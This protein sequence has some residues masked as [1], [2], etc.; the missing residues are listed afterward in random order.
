MLHSMGFAQRLLFRKAFQTFHKIFDRFFATIWVMTALTRALQ[1]PY[2]GWSDTSHFHEISTYIIAQMAPGTF[3][4]SLWKMPRPLWQAS[5]FAAAWGRSDMLPAI[6]NLVRCVLTVVMFLM[7]GCAKP[8]AKEPPRSDASSD[9][10]F[11]W[12]RP[13]HPFANL[14][15]TRSATC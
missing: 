4:I 10:L 12:T 14:P 5:K 6:M 1:C 8:P 2:C 15:I 7:F 9:D 3:G 13:I 11:V